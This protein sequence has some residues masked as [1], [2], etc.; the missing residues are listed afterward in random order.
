MIKNVGSADKWVRYIIGLVL[1]LWG[2]LG[3]NGAAMWIVIVIGLIPIITALIGWCPIYS[4]FKIST[5]KEG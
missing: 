4:I 1:I 5:H 2:A 3:L